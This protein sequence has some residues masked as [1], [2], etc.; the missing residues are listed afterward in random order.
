MAD[1]RKPSKTDEELLSREVPIKYYG[2]ENVT[3]IYADQV[4]VSHLGGVF[5]LYFYQMQ[6]PP[7][8]GEPTPAQLKELQE[9]I[10]DVPARCVARVV[11]TPILM[12]QFSKAIE[13]NVARYKAIVEQELL[14][15]KD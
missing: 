3:S 9:Q 11:L 6:L 7:T 15:K 4:V 2:N 5:T 14:K 10:K 1:D 8:V 13:T 12:E